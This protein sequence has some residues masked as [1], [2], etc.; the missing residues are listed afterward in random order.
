[1]SAPAIERRFGPYG[2]R[3]VPET[4]VPALDEPGDGLA[5]GAPTLPTATSSMPCCAIM[6]VGPRR[7]TT[8]PGCRS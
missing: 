7:F 8:P 6:R 1:M 4:L 5:R 2:G 3:Y